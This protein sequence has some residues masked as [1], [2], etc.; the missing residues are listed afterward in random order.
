MYDNTKEVR[1]AVAKEIEEKAIAIEMNS[2]AI[3]GKYQCDKY[4]INGF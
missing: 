3:E 4:C 2:I 1:E